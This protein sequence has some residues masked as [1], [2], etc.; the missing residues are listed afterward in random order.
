MSELR[1]E[2]RLRTFLKGRIVYNNG[3]ASLDCLVRD[4]SPT[5]ARLALTETA[6]LPDVFELHIPN[7]DKVLRAVLRWRRS[8]GVGVAF[9]EEQRPTPAPAVPQDTSVAALM[10]RIRELEGEN[11]TLRRLLAEAEATMLDVMGG[12]GTAEG[13]SLAGTTPPLPNRGPAESGDW[14]AQAARPEATIQV[15]WADDRGL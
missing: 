13:P 3:N 15:R 11:A 1:K 2:T 7:K 9:P 8:D 6:A 5:G 14:R 4:L 10:Q 12:P